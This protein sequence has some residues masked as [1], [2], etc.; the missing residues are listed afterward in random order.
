M[1]TLTKAYL[2]SHLVKWRLTWDKKDLYYKPKGYGNKFITALESAELIKN[3]STIVSTGLA[4]NGRCSIFFWAIREL[5]LQTGHPKDLTWLSVGAQGGRGKVPGTIEELGIPGILKKYIAGHV[6]TA[7]SLLKL[8]DEGELELHC[9]GQGMLSL[10]LEAQGRGMDHLDSKI[11]LGTFLDP[12]VGHGSCISPNAKESYISVEDDKLRYRLPKIDTALASAPY[13]DREG[14]IYFRNA[15]SLTEIKDAAAAAYY[16][17]GKVIIAVGDIIDRSMEEISIPSEQVSYIVVN[18]RNE[19]TG[20]IP[21]KKYWPMFTVNSHVDTH[22]AIEEVK[23]INNFLKITPTR[24]EIDNV[25]ARIAAD[26]FTNIAKKGSIVN[27]GVGYPEEVCRILYESGLYKELTFT[28]ETG[29]YGGLPVPG[30]F[31]GAAINPTRIE[32]SSWM[33]KLYKEHLDIAMLGFLEVDSFGNVNVSN[34]GMTMMDYVGPGGFIDI[35]NGAKQIIFV[36]S[37]MAHSKMSIANGKLKIEKT[38]T[39]KF[40]DKVHEITFSGDQGIKLGKRVYYIT[41]VGVFRL[42]ERGLELVEVMPG[43][44]IEKDILQVSKAKIH[45]PADAE[46]KIIAPEIIS[47]TGF[48]LQLQE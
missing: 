15:A 24:K 43:I 27:I 14:N 35:I 45:L 40:I 42:T 6:E 47:G 20:S 9:M 37:W 18:P 39:V 12:R 26:F 7:K 34:R 11:G 44:D 33:F 3:S 1:N 48:H 30:I 8:A 46:V 21:Q 25:L 32:S 41:N 10:L 2:V 17:G 22:K 31:F 29:V 19:Q 4:A 36:G 38:G 16:N 23:F 28:T 13:A 5:F